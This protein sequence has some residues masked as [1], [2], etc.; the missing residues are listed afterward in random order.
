M[1]RTTPRILVATIAG[2]AG[3]ILYVVM[4]VTVADWLEAR[5]WAAR[6]LYFAIAGVVWVLPARWLMIW[7]AR[8]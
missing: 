2:L 5:H 4:T 1:K 8:G 6:A 3:F 7:A